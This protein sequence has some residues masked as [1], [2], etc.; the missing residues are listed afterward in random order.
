MKRID[1]HYSVDCEVSESDFGTSLDD[2]DDDST[3]HPP[4]A[5]PTLEELLEENVVSQKPK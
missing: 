3:F 5:Q 1:S 2:S 4:T